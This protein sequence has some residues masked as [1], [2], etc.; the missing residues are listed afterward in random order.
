MSRR[1]GDA[2]PPIKGGRTRAP[3]VNR[4]NQDNESPREGSEMRF[5]TRLT[6]RLRLRHPIIQ[7]PMAGGATTVDLVEA[8]CT[9]GGLGFFGAAYW[10]PLQ[11]LEH[12]IELRRRTDRPFG[13]NLFAPQ[14]QPAKADPRP[15]VEA[16]TAYHAEL[17]LEP[18]AAPEWT[19][20]PFNDQFEAVLEAGPDVFSFTFG[21]IPEEAM[22]A[23]KEQNIFVMGTATTVAEALELERLGVDAVVA[24]GSEAGGHRGTFSA[25][26]ERAMVGTAALVP[27]V[28]DAVTIPVVASGGIMD[29]RGLAAA[30][31][32]GSQ[33]AQ[34][35]TA[36]LT[37]TEAGVSR[38]HKQAILSADEDS[39]R[40]TRA[41]S[42]RPARGIANRFV[43]EIEL[44]DE[45]A[46][47][48]PF[49]LQNTLTRAL[50]KAAGAQGR[51]EFI[52]LWAG[53]GL[54]LAR[55]GT[56][57]ELIE[58]LAAELEMTV[59]RLAASEESAVTRAIESPAVDE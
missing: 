47:L 45:G 13:M 19:G 2:S 36:F 40:I 53:Q 48:L 22:S 6:K 34:L 56:A 10:T 42:G 43:R 46:R 29:G 9:A 27:Q 50:R 24:Q 57:A 38:A 54:R 17:G 15:M 49:P 23:L 26:F 8:V 7:A 51:T 11:I 18:P 5:Q 16:M 32:L 31:A 41:F 55:A 33:A 3:T 30:L 12:A 52:S 21:T 37:C 59:T 58:R 14:P 44:A 4:D 28:V 39:T 1:D 35:G 25:E 20:D